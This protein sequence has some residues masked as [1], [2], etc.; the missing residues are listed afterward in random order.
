MSPWRRSP[1]S[2]VVAR[3]TRLRQTATTTASRRR[4][5][6]PT[7]PSLMTPATTTTSRV[8]DPRPRRLMHQAPIAVARRPSAVRHATRPAQRTEA[9]AA[10][11]QRTV[12][13]PQQTAARRRRTVALNLAAEAAR[14]LPTME[15]DS[16]MIT[17]LV[18]IASAEFRA[19]M[20]CVAAAVVV[21]SPPT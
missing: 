12:G 16:G 21:A 13:R 6:Q 15:G 14:C 9:E 3:P 1:A 8:E 7:R 20:R 18:V 5:P 2:S 4:A 17:H 11:R 10:Q 19:S